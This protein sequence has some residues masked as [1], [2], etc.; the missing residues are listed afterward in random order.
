MYNIIKRSTVRL[1]YHAKIDVISNKLANLINLVSAYRVGRE[2]GCSFLWIDEGGGKVI[3]AGDRTKFHIDST[4]RLKPSTYIQCDGGVSIGK[5]CH[6]TRGLTIYSATHDYD[7]RP[8]IPYDE[9]VAKRPVT[10][11]DFVWCGCHVIIMP[12]VTIGEGAIIGAGSVVTKDV[13]NYAIA[14]GNPAKVI[15]SRDIEHFELLRKLERFY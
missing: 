15:K 8:K 13:P 4:S 6:L 9:I 10:I 5:Y 12:G 14:A 7:H 11:R 1:L 3:L 2:T